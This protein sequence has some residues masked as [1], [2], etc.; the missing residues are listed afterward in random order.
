MFKRHLMLGLLLALCAPAWA[1]NDATVVNDANAK[2]LLLGSHR[3]SLQWVSW[4]TFGKAEV[5]ETDGQLRIDGEQALDGNY[6]RMHGAITQVDAKSFVF[7]GDVE[8]RVSYLNEGKPCMRHGEMT[9][10][11]M[12][13]RRYWRMKEMDNPC[14]NATDYV[15]VFLR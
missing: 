12:G 9:F 3:F 5:S 6:V 8:T 10:R 15:D 4:D 7:N 2:Q 1:G 14:D 11:I 13:A